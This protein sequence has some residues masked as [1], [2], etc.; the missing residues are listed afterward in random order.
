MTRFLMSAFALFWCI[1][2]LVMGSNSPGYWPMLIMGQV[3]LVGSVVWGAL[4]ALRN[5]EGRK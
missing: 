1:S 2:A 5:H 3:W 4:T